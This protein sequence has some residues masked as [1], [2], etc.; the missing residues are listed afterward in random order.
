MGRQRATPLALS[1]PL[2]FPPLRPIFL[3]KQSPFYSVRGRSAGAEP[4]TPICQACLPPHPVSQS[5]TTL[6]LSPSHPTTP[7]GL[8]PI[9]SSP[10]PF[11]LFPCFSFTPAFFCFATALTPRCCRRPLL[12]PAPHPACLSVHCLSTAV[13][14]A[15]FFVPAGPLSLYLHTTPLAALPP[16]SWACHTHIFVG[17]TVHSLWF[18]FLL[19]PLTRT[20]NNPPT[21]P[22]CCLLFPA[23]AMPPS[24]QS[25]SPASLSPVYSNKQKPPH[26][27]VAAT[28]RRAHKPSD[29]LSPI[30]PGILLTLP[31]FVPPIRRI[32]TPHTFVGQFSSQGSPSHPPTPPSA[33]W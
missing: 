20:L 2:C 28:Q 10:A 9:H 13:L 6:L 24:D 18:D 22:L 19:R 21:R 23:P 26:S 29:C 7:P 1:L 32:R 17:S 25:P 8:D 33:C 4:L 14:C 16:P 31:H 30:P 3:T 11:F 12:P 5:C 15:R 27:N